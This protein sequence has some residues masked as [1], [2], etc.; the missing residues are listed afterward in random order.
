MNRTL[1]ALT[2]I[3]VLTLPFT[4]MTGIFGMNFTDF[5]ELDPASAKNSV[6]LCSTADNVCNGMSWWP[7]TGY[8]MFWAL[9]CSC[10]SFLLLFMV[11]FSIF[12]PLTG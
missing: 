4:I 6:D 12:R 8:K 3:T 2:L 5:W 9:I 11:R 1:Y 10:L 7:L